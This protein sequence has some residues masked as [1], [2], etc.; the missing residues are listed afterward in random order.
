MGPSAGAAGQGHQ[1][2]RL[3]LASSMAQEHPQIWAVKAE[4]GTNKLR[5]IQQEGGQCHA[6]CHCS[7]ATSSCPGCVGECCSRSWHR[8]TRCMGPE[9]VPPECDTGHHSAD[10]WAKK[11]GALL[12]SPVPCSTLGVQPS[13]A[14]AMARNCKARMGPPQSSQPLIVSRH[15]VPTPHLHLIYSMEPEGP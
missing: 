4:Q 10:L 3:G 12:I 9:C 14:A 6:L 1:G 2:P 5:V 11:A 7:P 15:L 13:E 8:E